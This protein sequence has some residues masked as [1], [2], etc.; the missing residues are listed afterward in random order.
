MAG[1]FWSSTSAFDELVNEATSELRPS[2]SEDILKNLE[3]NDKI[4]SK[5]VPAKDAMRSLKRRLD[6][7]NPNVRLLALGLIDTCVKNSG[8]HFLAEIASREF[9]DNLVSLLKVPALHFEVK[10]KMLKL[11]QD[12]SLLFE[13][14]PTL[15]YVTEVYKMLKKEGFTFPPVNA[16][17]ATSAMADTKTAPEWIDGDVCMRCRTAFTFTNRKHHCRNCGQ[18]F[19]QGCSSKSMPLPHFGLLEDV[20]V[21]DP[22]HTKLTKAKKERKASVDLKPHGNDLHHSPSHR[23]RS[24]KYKSPQEIADEEL[25][26]AIQMSL[27]ESNAQT[28]HGPRRVPASSEPPIVDRSTHPTHVEEEDPDLLAAIEA[29]LREAKAPQASAPVEEDRAPTPRPNQFHLP[30]PN[31]TRSI[32]IY[33][34]SPLE[35]DA[36]L[37]FSQTIEQAQA[38]GGRDLTRYPN[39]NELYEQASALRPRFAMSL[40]DTGKKEQLLMEMNDKL[41]QAV[42]LYDQLLTEQL[43]YHSRASQPAYRQQQYQQYQ[44]PQQGPSHAYAQSP[45]PVPMTHVSPPPM[46]QQI[47]SP[48]P[49][50]Q[51][52][53]ELSRS[54]VVDSRYA[55]SPMP[56]QRQ[57]SL[58]RSSFAP[59]PQQPLADSRYAQGPI[60]P[61]LAHAQFAGQPHAPPNGSAEPPREQMQYSAPSLQHQAY[62]PVPTTPAPEQPTTQPLSPSYP[63]Q[64]APPQQSFASPPPPPQAHQYPTTPSSYSSAPKQASQPQSS[65][66]FPSFPSAPKTEPLAYNYAPPIEQ[67][68][69]LLISFD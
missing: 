6:H 68:E 21:C 3:V 19:D 8:D 60:Q 14:K 27:E 64:Y 25:Q 13:N 2:G 1:I 10:N 29:S 52:G 15:G 63:S 65:N 69:A 43:S 37:T 4:K 62:T 34:L 33:D 67:K 17:I 38:E 9:M 28:Q 50:Q 49:M 66:I 55:A 22:C 59:P 51:S 44:Q 30:P 12:W 40:D 42:K 7:Q 58:A 41:S 24:R 45:A 5:A 53:P 18:V 31:P 54:P 46:H 39:V 26:R 32:P 36:I 47:Y 11:I 57:D 23:S 16:S 56:P 48:P 20:R 35:S 61:Q